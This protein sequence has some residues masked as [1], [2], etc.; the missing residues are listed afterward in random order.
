M[1]KR[2][3]R[4]PCA[5]DYLPYILIAAVSG[6]IPAMTIK[7]RGGLIDLASG[8]EAGE[9]GFFGLLALLIGMSF[10]GTVCRA[11]KERLSERHRIR[12]LAKIDAERLEKAARTAFPVTETERFHALWRSSADAP[13]LDDRIFRAAGDLTEIFV[14]LGL[15]LYVLWTMDPRIA[16]G[17]VL[18]LT[19][20]ILLNRELARNTEGFWPKYRENMRRTNYLSSLL[21]QREYAGERKLFSF[22]EEIDRRYAEA[23]SKAKMENAKLGRGRFRIEAPMKLMFAAYSVMAVR[24][25]GFPA[26]NWRIF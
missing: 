10:F 19:A 12:A 21:M 8:V 22:D 1:S 23:F 16:G 3:G 18:L 20:G 13:E 14:R 11:G 9:S 25:Y 17:I 2:K 26:E 24:Y 7:L 6:A 4:L 5:G 15:S